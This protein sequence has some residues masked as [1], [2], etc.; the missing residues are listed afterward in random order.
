ME[1]VVLHRVGFLAY[2]CPKQGQ[3]FKPSAAPPPHQGSFTNDEALCMRTKYARNRIA[4]IFVA[5]RVNVLPHGNGTTWING[6]S[7]GRWWIYNNPTQCSVGRQL[8]FYSFRILI[9]KLWYSTDCCE[10]T[11]SKSFFTRILKMDGFESSSPCVLLPTLH[12]NDKNQLNTTS[13][14]WKPVYQHSA[15]KF[16]YSLDQ[17]MI[18]LSYFCCCYCLVE[19]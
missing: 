17:I 11:L 9:E 1:A 6:S 16:P 12:C 2:S 3:D 8:Q 5:S 13:L 4:T 10:F 15:R 18:M 19:S 7:W 14:N